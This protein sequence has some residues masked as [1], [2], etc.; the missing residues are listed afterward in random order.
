MERTLKRRLPRIR[1]V[2]PA[3]VA[4]IDA[5]VSQREPDLLDISFSTM[6]FICRPPC[7]NLLSMSTRAYFAWRFRCLKWLRAS[8]IGGATLSFL[9]AISLAWGPRT[10]VQRLGLGSP[11]DPF[12]LWLSAVLFASL[13]L[14]YLVASGDVR[15]YSAIIAVAIGSHLTLALVFFAAARGAGASNLIR[16]SGAELLIGLALIFFWWPIRS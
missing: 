2:F 6:S 14:L 4:K 16:L 13:G 5:T 15:R 1:Y 11:N 3:R 7:Y 12:Y 9:M 8:L 10:T